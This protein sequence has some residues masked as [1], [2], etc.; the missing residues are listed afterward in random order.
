M[1]ASVVQSKSAAQN[2]G[3]ATVTVSWNSA[4]TAGNLLLIGVT[5]DDYRTGGGIPSGFT[6]SLNCKLET[7]HGA[8]VWWKVAAGGETSTT[9][10][11]G[12]ASPS[13]W[14]TAEISGLA[15]STPLD[16]SNGQL[17]QSSGTS[18]TTPSI[19]PSAGER[20]LV[21]Q[22]GGSASSAFSSGM[23]AW[24]N[25]FTEQQDIFTTLG[26]GTRDNAGMAVRLSVTG[27]GSTGFSTGATWDGGFT[28]TART[29]IIL[30]FTVAG[31]VAATAGEA[32]PYTLRAPGRISPAGLWSPLPFGDQQFGS[33]IPL[34]DT[35]AAADSLAETISAPLTDAGSGADAASVTAALSVSDSAGGTDALAVSIPVPLADSA[36]AADALT[37]TAV[38]APADTGTGTDQLT[39]ATAAAL[40]DTG[41]AADAL[42]VL[43]AVPP[44]DTGTA[45]DAVTATA[46]APLTDAASAADALTVGGSGVIGVTDTATGADAINVT[47]Q[48]PLAEARTAAD[49]LAAAVTLALADVVAAAEQITAT[50][51]LTFTDTVT[52]ADALAGAPVPDV[53]RG[54]MHGR[55]RDGS[56]AG[57]R[58]RLAPAVMRRYRTGPDASGRDRTGSETG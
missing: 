11:I 17:A 51:A 32:V 47:A 29:G 36:A 16:I 52:A 44:T 35:A 34:G 13:C 26:S 50:A 4:A 43:V 23:G 41:S 21:A 5:S 7:F 40:A 56:A 39:A 53:T 37:V 33:S 25:S 57:A 45:A 27:D 18:Y 22:I 31:A 55:A 54:D 58:A 20:F 3:L 46:T 2:T 8:Y 42:T 19:V 48:V 10:T 24:T 49:A 1:S 12:S 9:Y 6:E 38:T 30:A 28:V 14:W 15:T